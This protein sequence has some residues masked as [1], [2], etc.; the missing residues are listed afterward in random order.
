M[1]ATLQ[2]IKIFPFLEIFANMILK[3]MLYAVKYRRNEIGRTVK[4]GISVQCLVRVLEGDKKK[5]NNSTKHKINMWFNL[6]HL[7]I[8]IYYIRIGKR[9][10]DLYVKLRYIIFMIMYI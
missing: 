1:Y 2:E 5:K 7:Y 4:T 9:F 6:T 10:V 3:G 8:Y